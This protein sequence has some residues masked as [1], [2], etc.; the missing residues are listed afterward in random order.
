MHVCMCAD[1]YTCMAYVLVYNRH[2]LCFNLRV[3]AMKEMQ[4][5]HYACMRATTVHR[6]ACMCSPGM[7]VSVCKYVAIYISIESN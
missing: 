1:V 3:S 5:F 2:I 6:T 4:G 7:R